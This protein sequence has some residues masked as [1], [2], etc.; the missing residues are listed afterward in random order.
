[1]SMILNYTLNLDSTDKLQNYLTDLHN[2]L[3]TN[4][5]L[6]NSTKSEIINI[7]TVII[8]I[9]PAFPKIFINDMPIKLSF[10]T[11]YLGVKFDNKL[12]FDKH[13]FSLKHTTTYYATV[14]TQP[15]G[16]KGLTISTVLLP[17]FTHWTDSKDLTKL[18][19]VPPTNL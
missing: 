9:E 14:L 4:D 19:I 12:N 2:L 5:S 1:M 6:L 11:K 3:T 7:S 17:Y 16:G 8:N 15:L 18:L 10:S 13:I